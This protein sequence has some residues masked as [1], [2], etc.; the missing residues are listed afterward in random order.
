MSDVDY[1]ASIFV[2]SMVGFLSW[3]SHVEE[4]DRNL[5]T[6]AFMNSHVCLIP[7]HRRILIK[8]S[9]L[10]VY[11]IF[12]IVQGSCTTDLDPLSALDPWRLFS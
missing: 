5:S 3:R 6:T 11:G 7:G 9:V 10:W 1:P 8:R 12:C 2:K 4:H